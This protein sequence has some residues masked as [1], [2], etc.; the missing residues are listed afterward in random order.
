MDWGNHG[1]DYS[2][3]CDRRYSRSVMVNWYGL[4]SLMLGSLS[5]SVQPNDRGVLICLAW[6]IAVYPFTMDGG[7]FFLCELILIVAS[8][9]NTIA[10]TQDR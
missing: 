5:A 4:M 6:M 8:L 2:W 10:M 1:F 9:A 7:S 3:N